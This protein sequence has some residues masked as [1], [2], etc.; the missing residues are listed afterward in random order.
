[1]KGRVS[2]SKYPDSERGKVE[3]RRMK[4]AEHGPGAAR[5][6]Y[7]VSRAGFSPVKKLGY[8]DIPC[9][10]QGRR[11]KVPVKKGGTAKV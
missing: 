6:N 9:T 2:Q 7:R 11:R 5:L 1:M 8:R 3:A 4:L 10:C